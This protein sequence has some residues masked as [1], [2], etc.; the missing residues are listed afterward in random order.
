MADDDFG[1]TAFTNTRTLDYSIASCTGVDYIFLKESQNTAPG[2]ND[3]GWLSCATMGNINN[4]IAASADA[5]CVSL[6]ER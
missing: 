2:E 4:L 5:Y 6:D 1:S 3:A